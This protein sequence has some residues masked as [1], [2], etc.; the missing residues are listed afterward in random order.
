VSQAASPTSPARGVYV[1]KARSDIYTVMLG[2]SLAAVLL[3]ILF[4]I[5][6]LGS[7]NWEM[8]APLAAAP[9]PRAAAT[10]TA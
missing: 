2:I 10:A 8:Q 4:L 5:L 1:P 7:Y 9:T 3:G 6:E